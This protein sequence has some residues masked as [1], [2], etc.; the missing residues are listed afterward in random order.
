VRL[1]DEPST[2]AAKPTAAIVTPAGVNLGSVQLLAN[3]APHVLVA[4]R[5]PRPEPG[6]RNCELQRS[7]GTWVQVGS[8]DVA[9]IAA[10]VWATGID[11][12][13]LNATAMRITTQDG[14]LLATATFD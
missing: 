3:P 1:L 8:W 11:T 5:A 7:D 12:S 10:G 2:E 4:I 6:Q 9:D 13:L 14:T